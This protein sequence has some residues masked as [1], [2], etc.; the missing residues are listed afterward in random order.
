[1]VILL[2][3]HIKLIT[4]LLPLSEVTSSLHEFKWFSEIPSFCVC[5]SG[6][7]E[8]EEEW[9]WVSCPDHGPHSAPWSRLFKPLQLCHVAKWVGSP[10]LFDPTWL[11]CGN[12]WILGSPSWCLGQAFNKFIDSTTSCYMRN[13]S[14]F[15][16]NCEKHPAMCSFMHS[17]MCSFSLSHSLINI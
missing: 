14:A 11:K 2:N 16:L 4:R 9:W 8:S 13:R 7:P 5:S 3:I 1:M 17:A 10:S 12:W 15:N 6:H